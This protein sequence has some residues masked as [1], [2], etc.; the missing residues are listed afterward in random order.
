MLKNLFLGEPVARKGM[1]VGIV[2]TFLS[3]SCG[4][5]VFITYASTIFARSGT[6]IST[7]LSSIVLALLQI[8]GTLLAANYVDNYG[9]K[10][11]LLI[12]LT[13]CK[14]GLSAMA[15]YLYCDSLGYDVSMVDWIPVASL[16]FVILIS[17]VGIV[18]LS[19]VCLAEALPSKVRSIGLTLGGLSMATSSFVIVALYPI[20][21]EIVDLHGCMTIFAATCAFGTFFVAFAVDETKGKTLDLL[22]EEKLDRA[23]ENA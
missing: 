19:L 3:Q 11:L 8:A 10:P 4:A 7:E 15:A 14:F 5:F 2:L 1:L 21:L 22:K 17:S 9:R 23:P 20:L 18:P 13:G 6:N 12:S 16:G